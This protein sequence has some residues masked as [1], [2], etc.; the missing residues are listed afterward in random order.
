[1]GW[2]VNTSP[3]F[4]RIAQYFAPLTAAEPGAFGLANDA[5]ALNIPA[6]KQL[7]LTSDS[8][9]EGWHVPRGVEAT[10]LATKLVRRNL[11]DLAAMGAVPW[12]YMI[13]LHLPAAADDGYV[14]GFAA[15]LQHEQNQFGMVLIGGDSTF[16]G[17]HVHA[18][19]TVLGL[20]THTHTRSGAQPG[21]D[22]YVSGNIGEGALAL[23]LLEGKLTLN[24]TEAAPLWQRYFAPPPR[25]ALGQALTGVATSVIDVS[26][27]LL[28]DLAHLARGSSTSMVLARAAIPLH[29]MASQMMAQHGE[30]MMNGGDDYELA[31]TA[32][33]QAA[34]MLQQ[35]AQQI[36][37]PLTRIGTVVAA[38][39]Q[40]VI[41]A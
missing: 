18:S 34:T 17:E 30:Q 22:V 6:G 3:E 26:D 23:M 21:D 7:I 38:T 39:G 10:L 5:A 28:D 37:L 32:P 13:N 35:L 19:M 9:I 16:G 11:S 20:A 41:L 4:S 31:F 33:T 24:E 29:A 15:A 1:M 40:P 27:G 25:L 12:R 14:A 2:H 8:C 36:H